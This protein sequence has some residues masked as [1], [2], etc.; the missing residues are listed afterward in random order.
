MLRHEFEQH[1]PRLKH[2][3]PAGSRLQ[4]PVATLHEP[5]QHRGLLVHVTGELPNMQLHTPPSQSWVQH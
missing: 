5:L 1:W 2:S 4:T 3:E